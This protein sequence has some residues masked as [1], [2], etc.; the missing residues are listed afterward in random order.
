[1]KAYIFPGQGSQFQGMAADLYE[2]SDKARAVI[3]EADDVLGFSLSQMMF[4]GSDEDL[5]RTD[6]TQPAIYV[7]SIALKEAVGADFQP[8]MVAGHS[9]GEFSALAAAGGITWQEGL[10]LIKLRA[11][12]MQQACTLAPS[13]MAAI[14]GLD[15]EVVDVCC[16]EISDTVV[17]A[18]YN[19][20]GQVVISGTVTG[21]DT[22]CEVLL[23]KGA[24]RAIKLQVGGA[25][26]SPLMEPA[27][28]ELEEAIRATDIVVPIA[29]IFQN[30]TGQQHRE[31]DEIRKNLI[32]QL[33]A[34]VKWAASIRSMYIAGATT[35]IE[36]GPGKV[37]TG[38]VR[39]IERD[40]ITEQLELS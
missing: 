6:I 40:V 4:E 32:A 21:V 15:D 14:L 25:F 26:H 39:K 36:V 8:D 23:Q 27:R 13:T 30:V 38:L 35:F 10:K 16:R 28:E 5:K 11:N 9:L 22:A 31:V 37:L 24:K 12:A 20:P 29:P 18:N 17:A 7:H 34:P 1:M 33:T 19:S 2:R 3:D